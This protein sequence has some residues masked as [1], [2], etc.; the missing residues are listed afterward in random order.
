[1]LAYLATISTASVAL[2]LLP[3][4]ALAWGPVTHIVH[5][6]T[7]LANL[8]CLP[9]SLQAILANN[10]DY[11]L[12]GCVGADIIQAKAYT[13]SLATHCH[14]W[15]LAW[16]LV[17]SAHSD[18]E[19]A[20]AWGYM[21]HL[22]ADV[23]SHNHFVPSHLLRSFDARTAGHAYWE[24]RADGLQDKR[25]RWRLREILE[26]DYPECDDLVS[27]V[28]EHTLFS[29]KTNKRIF[30]SLMALS[31]LERWQRFMKTVNDRSRY[32][33]T[34]ETVDRYNVAAIASATDLLKR[35]K[36]S[37]TQ[38]EDPTGSA[39]LRRAMTL[40]RKLRVLKRDNRLPAGLED[41]LL[42]KLLVPDILARTSKAA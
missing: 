30:D 7:I 3:T 12:Y 34:R 36:S 39:M 31:K 40:R 22:G 41:Q 33:L 16:R 21:T 9:A 20:F 28:V 38:K 29:F 8:G 4:E 2:L 24:A 1:M 37:Y 19:Q 27:R 5:G 25:Y 10:V 15:P 14:R 23:V 6:S 17:S 13:K 42:S 18:E 26:A 32:E 35:G 11:Y